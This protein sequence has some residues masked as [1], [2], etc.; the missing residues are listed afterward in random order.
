MNSSLKI[1]RRTLLNMV[2]AAVIPE[3]VAA[4][5][6]GP[7]TAPAQASASRKP[8]VLF[9]MTDQQRFDT[10]A[11]LGNSSIYTPNIDRL[12]AR[13]M[14][15]TNAYSTCPVCVPARYTIRTGCDPYTTRIFQNG[16]P[17]LEDGMAATM[18]GRCGPYLAET[19]R[20]LG[21]RTFGI[22]KF[23]T[24]PW[25]EE[26]GYE[27]HLRSE[28]LYANP[29]QRRGDAFA[30][31]IATEHPKFDFIEGLMGE[32]TEMYNMPQMSPMPADVTV[33]GW[34]AAR[35]VEQ[36][37]NKDPRPYFGFVSFIGPHPP[38]APPIPFNRIYSPDKM[39]NPICGN[40]DD[41]HL[42]E[43]IP[44]MNYAIWSEDINN[45]HA[46]VA[47]ARYY[48]E[49]T[50]IDHCIGQ[51]LDAVEKR[52]DAANTVI[53]FYSDHGEHLGDHH[54]WQKESFFEVS[55]HVPFLLSW[56]EKIAAAKTSSELVCLT[57][58]FAIAT[59]AAGNVQVREGMD[60]L[61]ML[62]DAAPAR[63]TLFGYY[64]EPGTRRF[65]IMARQDKWKY[66]FLANGCREQLF[67]LSSDPHELNN[68]AQS[69]SAMAT[70]L[71]QVAEKACNRLE[72]R[73]VLDA[74]GLRRLPFEPRPLER[75]Y[76]FDR[77]RGVTGFAANARDVIQ[78]YFQNSAS[79]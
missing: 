6:A 55:C 76:Q 69:Q 58:L 41:D 71:R 53:C 33:E 36:L 32:R 63:Q 12:V 22:G 23:H 73:S 44:Y 42:D 39:A 13:G 3:S 46:R 31:W 35:A 47:R 17:A 8:N 37:A 4:A 70:R 1:N 43:Q 60:V 30:H 27:V 24:S 79:S 26:L 65:K 45:S 54:A 48:G 66:I 18:R 50:Y 57:D 2:P 20:D 52:D 59:G 5:Q 10:I 62:H 7:T 77:S 67:D 25:N 40:L 28:E 49:I 61:G 72:L 75:I 9:I 56:P 21:Y 14:T 29:E 34:A 11:A 68:L 64:G 51:I 15:F 38:F 16:K 19:M 78:G 74:N